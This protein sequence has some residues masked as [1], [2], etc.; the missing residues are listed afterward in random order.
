MYNNLIEGSSDTGGANVSSPT[1]DTDY[2]PR[3]HVVRIL[4]SFVLFVF[5]FV[6]LFVGGRRGRDSIVV[7]F[8]TTYIVYN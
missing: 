8:T 3:V 6:L 2:E 5:V 4:F 1:S 7:A